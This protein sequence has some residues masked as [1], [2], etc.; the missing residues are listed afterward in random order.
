MFRPVAAGVALAALAACGG[1]D[2]PADDAPLAEVQ[3]RAYSDGGA[4]QIKLFTVLREGETQGLHTAL[5][6]DGQRRVLWDPAGSFSLPIVPERGDVLHGI[7]PRVE[8]AYTD[9]HV[10]GDIE[11]TVQ[12]LPVPPETAARL[13]GLVEA[14]GAADKATCARETSAILREAG[15]DLPQTWYPRVLMRGFGALPGVATVRIDE[16]TVDTSHGVTFVGPGAG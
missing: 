6:I 12:T 7:T 10:R 13:T 15:F 11:M 4:T 8:L 9:Y 1:A 5:L 2:L 14:H 16:A 3:R